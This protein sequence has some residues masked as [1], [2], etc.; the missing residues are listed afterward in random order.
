VCKG[1]CL[2]LPSSSSSVMILP[3]R[4]CLPWHGLYAK[5]ARLGVQ[6]GETVTEEEEEEEEEDSVR[7]STFRPKLE[8]SFCDVS[9]SLSFRSEKDRVY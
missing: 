4:A 7:D 3:Q 2:I 5:Q 8:Q 9:N 6:L 1:S